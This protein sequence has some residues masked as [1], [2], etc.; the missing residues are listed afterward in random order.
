M[1]ADSGIGPLYPTTAAAEQDATRR[2]GRLR[3]PNPPTPLVERR[4]LLDRLSHAVDTAPLTVLC[5]PAGAG[6][7]VLVSH[8]ARTVCPVLGWMTATE[9]DNDPR[10]FWWHVRSALTEG[11]AVRVGSKGTLFPG[12]DDVDLLADHLLHSGRTVVLVIDGAERLG[13]RAAFKGLAEL[14]DGAGGLLRVVLTSRHQPPMP[15]HR[16]RLEG[17]VAEL[18]QAD[19]DFT[20]PEVTEL[21]ERLAGHADDET[22]RGVLRRTEGWA[23]GARMA[24]LALRPDREGATL[25]R[26][27]ADYLRAEVLDSLSAAEQDLLMRVTIVAEVSPELAAALAGRRD[28]DTTLKELARRNAFV[29]SVPTRPGHHRFHPLLRDLLATRRSATQEGTD[30]DLQRIASESFGTA[31]QLVPAVEHAVAAGDWERAAAWTVRLMGL[32]DLMLSTPEGAALADLFRGLPAA[33]GPD[34]RLVRAALALGQGDSARALNQLSGE[35]S[36]SEVEGDAGRLVWAA[37]LT[38]RLS[39]LTGDVAATLEAAAR[40]RETFAMTEG[41][42][43]PSLGSL[44]A[45]VRWSEGTAYVHAGGLDAASA[46]LED[47]AAVAA[48]GDRDQLTVHCLSMLALA[49]ACRGRLTRAREV[50]DRAEQVLLPHVERKRVA[51]WGPAGATARP[52]GLDLAD[53]WVSLDRQDL[54]RAAYALS[55]ARRADNRADPQL[56]HWISLLLRARLKRDHGEGVG[57]RRLLQHADS[58]VGWLRRQFDEEAAAVGAPA[59][60]AELS[61]DRAPSDGADEPVPGPV[62]ETHEVEAMLESARILWIRGDPRASRSA[63][64]AALDRARGERLRRPFAHAAPEVRAMLRDD[65]ELRSRADWLRPD[66]TTAPEE[67][68]RHTEPVPLVQELSEREI[69]V[70]RHLSALLTTEEIAAE[71]FI[72]ANTVRTHIRRIFGKFSVSRRHEAVRRARELDLV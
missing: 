64:A 61:R 44:T 38:A 22:V 71:M 24:A 33:G 42:A 65:A 29:Q 43:A 34:V 53:A 37:I 2:P 5:A 52:A 35:H 27:A 11:G 21:L 10:A 39:G 51:P 48:G 17:T 56:L 70:L 28:A 57:A 66:R 46:A 36:S 72:S 15:L 59:S 45:L 4:R 6:K 47:A 12:A 9:R 63:V 50:G 62:S 18:C 13:A 8:W 31:G 68:H 54:P 7:T 32:V 69:E 67:S 1:R 3:I 58:R 30:R 26:L 16:Y 25:E 40:A 19:L 14:V 23:A 55:R 41:G 20:K 60:V 49:E